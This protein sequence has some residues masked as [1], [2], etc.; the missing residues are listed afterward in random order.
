MIFYPPVYGNRRNT[1]I[2]QKQRHPEI[3]DFV[4][5]DNRDLRMQSYQR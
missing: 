5:R 3:Q 1:K 2:I 4:E